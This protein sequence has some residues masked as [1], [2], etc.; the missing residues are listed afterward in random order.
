MNEDEEMYSVLYWPSVKV[1]A[2]G[3][4]GHDGLNPPM[5]LPQAHSQHT[6]LVMSR[7]QRPLWVRVSE[8]GK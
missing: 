3:L 5:N 6:K 4:E 7:I 8:S 1:V 2:K